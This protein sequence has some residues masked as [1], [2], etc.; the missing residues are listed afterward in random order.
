MNRA[1]RW[2]TVVMLLYDMCI[3][4]ASKRLFFRFL[5][6]PIW[7]RL[8]SLLSKHICSNNYLQIE[9]FHRFSSIFMHERLLKHWRCVRDSNLD[10]QNE[11]HSWMHWTMGS[12]VVGVCW[13][14]LIFRRHVC[15]NIRHLCVIFLL[16][17]YTTFVVITGLVL[18]NYKDGLKRKSVPNLWA[19]LWAKLTGS[20]VRTRVSGSQVCPRPLSPRIPPSYFSSICY[21]LSMLI[22]HKQGRDWS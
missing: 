17:I 13:F 5:T 20:G 16:I 7:L 11:R 19:V 8:F 15:G 9:E 3:G 4:F 22:S 18:Q 12:S 10:P 14:F 1:R 21:Q 2:Y 6:C